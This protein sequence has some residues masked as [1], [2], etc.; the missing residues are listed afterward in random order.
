MTPRG[1]LSV[2]TDYYVRRP[3]GSI[4]VVGE[5]TAASKATDLCHGLRSAGWDVMEFESARYLGGVIN[6]SIDHL[7]QKLFPR[8]KIDSLS[9]AV[10]AAASTIGV[11]YV[12]FFKGMGANPEV[13][14][15]LHRAGR[16]AICWYPDVSFDHPVFDARTI[17]MYDLFV[18]TKHFQLDYLR[19]QRGNHPTILIEHGYCPSA[20]FRLEPSVPADQR[21]FDCIFVGNHSA[22][23]EQWLRA[24]VEQRPN[25]RYAIAGGRWN[26]ATWCNNFNVYCSAGPIIG[27]AMA[28]LINHARIGIAVH[29]GPVG[30]PLGWSDDVSARTWEIPACGTFMLHVDSPHLRTLFDVDQQIGVFSTVEQLIEQID[31]F[32][33]NADQRDAMAQRAFDHVVPS[34][35]YTERGRTLAAL[36]AAQAGE[37]TVV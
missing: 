28:R 2:A 7:L 33:E 11:D 23:K 18:T 37:R 1:T 6:R 31:Y 4:L 29:H 32:L 21:P 35:S 30:H 12:L 10:D 19:E 20:H 22:Y 3:V 13:I 14:E 36:L 24:V 27:N 9:R 17:P 25:L 5:F 26:G 16:K 15:N 8:S 34:A